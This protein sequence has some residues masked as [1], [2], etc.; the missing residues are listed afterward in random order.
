MQNGF[1][2]LQA[3]LACWLA[4]GLQRV[5]I[6]IGCRDETFEGLLNRVGPDWEQSGRG[7]RLIRSLS[8]ILADL[9]RGTGP[10]G[11][12]MAGRSRGTDSQDLAMILDPFRVIFDDLGPGVIC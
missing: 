8:H 9:G 12:K 1:I 10:R 7:G 4:D 5:F 3:L 2:T 11:E 6:H